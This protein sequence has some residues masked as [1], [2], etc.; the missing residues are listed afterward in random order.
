MASNRYEIMAGRIRDEER[1]AAGLDAPDEIVLDNGPE[2]AGRAVDQWAHERVVW[3]RFIEPGKLVQDAFV[4]SCQGRL[5]DKCLDHHW[6]VGLSD[7]Q[8]TIESWRQDDH[9]SRPHGALVYR[10]PAQ[11][12]QFFE[13]TPITRQE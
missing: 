1:S 12:R 2:L 8:P 4:E 7:A 3:L 10:P 5:S 13:E 6:F 9:Q 11:F